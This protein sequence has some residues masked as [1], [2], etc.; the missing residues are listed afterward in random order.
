MR[1]VRHAAQFFHP[2]NFQPPPLLALTNPLG[3]SHGAA[4]SRATHLL[5][6][7]YFHNGAFVCADGQKRRSGI[8]S[9]KRR[10]W[11]SPNH[12]SL[13]SALLVAALNNAGPALHVDAKDLSF[14]NS[15][16]FEW[17]F[18]DGGDRN[19]HSSRTRHQDMDRSGDCGGT[20]ALGPALQVVLAQSILGKATSVEP[21]GWHSTTSDDDDVLLSRYG[22]DATDLHTWTVILTEINSCQAAR[23]LTGLAGPP[24]SL[25]DGHDKTPA[26]VYLSFL[27]RHHIGPEALCLLIEYLP[28][29]YN[30]MSNLEAG[31]MNQHAQ[32][33]FE[34]LR[35]DPIT[36]RGAVFRACI[37]LFRHARRVWP[38]SLPTISQHLVALL[39]LSPRDELAIIQG[40]LPAEKLAK[41]TSLFNRALYLISE[42]VSVE[43]FKSSVHQEAAQAVI[44]T[45]MAEH[46]P[47][48]IIN[49]EGYRGVMRVQ[50][51]HRKTSEEIEWARLKSPS[52]PPW[53]D[54]RT[55]MDAN[56]GLEYGISRAQHVMNRMQEAGYAMQKWESIA[57]IY[58]GWDSDLSPTIQ[59]RAFMPDDATAQLSGQVW[60]ARIRSTR[61][62][63]QAWACFLSYEDEDPHPNQDVYLAM[64]EKLVE[65]NKRHRLV[66]AHP[67]LRLHEPD[68]FDPIYP[69]DVKEVFPPP[70]S[71]HQATYTKTP[72]PT[73]H[74]LHQHM[75]QRKRQPSGRTLA[76]LLDNATSLK[77]GLE[78]LQASDK[79]YPSAVELLAYSMIEPH[80]LAHIPD[81]VFSAFVNLLMRFPHTALHPTERGLETNMAH[82]HSFGA[83]DNL[84]LR[85]P[86]ARAIYLLDTQRRQ[87]RPAWNALLSGL[88]RRT[89]PVIWSV[90]NLEQQIVTRYPDSSP[91]LS[92]RKE[93]L[94]K[95]VALKTAT[96]AIDVM[97]KTDISL[98][99]VGFRWLCII[100]E[101]AAKAAA[102]VL[103]QESQLFNRDFNPIGAEA[104][105]GKKFV[106]R[107]KDV[108]QQAELVRDQ[109][110]ALVGTTSVATSKTSTAVLPRLLATPSPA[111][112][113]AYI[114]ALGF[115][116]DYEGLKDLANWILRHWPEVGARRDEDRRG[117]QMFRKCI[118]ALRIFL[119]GQWEIGLRL[120]PDGKGN[121]HETRT[122]RSGGFEDGEGSFPTGTDFGAPKELINQVWDA[123]DSVEDWGGWASDE[124]VEAYME[125]M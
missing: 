117:V 52:W 122:L 106:H 101:N 57:M 125:R 32:E 107:A 27:R 48:L 42:P 75:L 83:T 116:R 115:L 86:L 9:R 26:F 38:E 121:S 65:E 14:T 13:K 99:V 64:F 8:R 111:V 102:Q 6:P 18:S 10:T 53:K 72:P 100:A 23:L 31:V 29:W 35:V 51:T 74:E 21:R 90:W 96:I 119:E 98:D 7:R 61:T 3:L 93:A 113:H 70:D 124:E 2:I 80:E 46:S 94:D 39:H 17:T 78:Y 22:Y 62:V 45:H 63:D 37:R 25:V 58:A 43:P 103:A 47:P 67:T 5:S 19:V 49:R 97:R 118:V 73:L 24:E 109:F 77:D 110:W 76:F 92:P 28:T 34:S 85:Q 91:T 56:V 1:H 84:N 30:N 66:E 15:E 71:V 68:H 104:K 123:V 11:S 60:A 108:E 88:A 44:L 20:A 12:S 120:Y 69:G 50:L 82:K 87:F 112:L 55:G 114:R 33:D 105:P 95:M 4:S 36:L 59:T 54:D 81:S 16:A 89:A 40:N 79:I 41:L